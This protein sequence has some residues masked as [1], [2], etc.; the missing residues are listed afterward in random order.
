MAIVLWITGLPGSGKSSVA[1]EL[2]KKRPEFVILRMD[3]LRQVATPRPT[4]LPEERDILYRSLVFM[5]ETLYGLGQDVIIDATGN[6]RV[7][8]ELARFLIPNFLEVYLKCPIQLCEEREKKRERPFGAP[9][10]I[11]KKAEEG[12][13]VPGRLAPYEEPPAPELVIDTENTSPEEAAEEI[14][15]YLRSFHPVQLE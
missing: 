3:A 1:E 13:P 8:R 5:A 10:D 12:W 9:R 4:Y 6:L 15:R 2:K 11:Y 14:S 7:W